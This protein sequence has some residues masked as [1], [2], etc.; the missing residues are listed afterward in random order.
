MAEYEVKS[1]NT[2]AFNLIKV[3]ILVGRL[4]YESWY[5]LNAEI[6]LVSDDTN[7]TIRPKEFW[8]ITIEVKHSEKNLLDF[9]MN[10]KGQ[11]IINSKI[12]DVGQR[13]I[14]K[15]TSI[16]KN[17][18]VLLSNE[19]KLLTIE[20]NLQWSKVNFDYKLIST[21]AFENLENKELLL[22]N[23]IHCTNYYITMMTSTVVTTTAG[24]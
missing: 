19:E 9:E 15:Q 13:F 24:I 6:H 18:F 22:L 3:D 16:L 8:G 2:K 4:K 11:I 23:A 7:F 17:I 20:P 1:T 10:W 5:S 14:L 12:N 21:D